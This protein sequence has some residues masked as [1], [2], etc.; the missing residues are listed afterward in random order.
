MQANTR[1]VA[2]IFDTNII[3]QVPLFQRPYVWTEER[4]WLPLWEDIE[5]LLDKHLRR[6]GKVRPHFLGAIVLEQVPHTAG[7]IETRLV[8]DGQQRFTTLQIF[9]I[10]ARNLAAEH[11]HRFEARFGPLV[12]NAESRIEREEDRYK[13][14]PTNS[15]RAPFRFVHDSPTHKDVLVGLKVRK[16][17]EGSNLIGAYCYFHDRLSKWLT[18]KSDTPNDDQDEV[19][20]AG[21][22]VDD[23][24]DTLWQVI[25]EGLQL[26]VI[27]LE[28]HDETQVIFET[29]N[30]HGTPLLPAD[31]IKNFLFRRAVADNADVDKLYGQHWERFESEFWRKEVKQGRLFRPRIDLFV[32]HYLSL[33]TRDD[34]RATH[35]FEAFKDF[36][37]DPT[38]FS[39]SAI[40]VPSTA[41]DHIAQLARYG[42]VFRVFYQPEG[43]PE[44]ALF[45]RRLDAVDTATVYPFLLYAYAEL[46]PG[47]QPEFDRILR[48]LE[49]F[50]M[51][52]LITGDTPKN[53]NK[54]FV[55]LVKHVDAGKVL[56]ADAVGV[57]LA[58]PT[59]PAG[60]FPTDQEVREAATGLRLYGRLS[61][62]KVRAVLEALDMAA[63]T[64]KSEAMT[65][66]DNL[67]IEHLMPQSWAEHWP[68]PLG[69]ETDLEAKQEA[70]ARRKRLVDQLGNLTLITGSLNPSISNSNWVKK[71]PEILKFNKL[72][73]TQYFHDDHAATW[74][75]E[76]IAVRTENLLGQ[77]LRIWPDVQ[78]G[79]G[80]LPG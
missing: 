25:Q 24:F 44:L 80:A 11:K 12:S 39:G 56:T 42:D 58:K 67:T 76:T 23:R 15:D 73:L 32:N 38:E 68:L 46:M 54:L 63:H 48:V 60:R 36:A 71:R 55:E 27:N 30:A 10:A 21:K 52:R 69:V 35:L 74:T 17:L 49:S 47:N 26:V 51:R 37:D 20:L 1:Q 65:L 59:G 53:Y 78:R 19:L 8:I 79:G 50:L 61:Q 33:M 22:G 4:N 9:L 57:V 14:W 31:L 66:P 2:N 28:E 3:F 64:S 77:L 70:I 62:K 18:G 29:L 34:V 43:H 13:V 40:P 6:G 16:E 72:N 75:E 45:L 7:S 5:S 41:A